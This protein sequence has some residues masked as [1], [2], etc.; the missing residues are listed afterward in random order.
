M[1]ARCAHVNY[2]SCHRYIQIYTSTPFS[3]VFPGDT[4]RCPDTIDPGPSPNLRA[5]RVPGVPRRFRKWFRWRTAVKELERC[6][7][8]IG[9]Q[10][11]DSEIIIDARFQLTSFDTVPC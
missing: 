10:G 8:E 3:R 4:L 11:P 5:D 1:F 7:R 9:R 6:W 2:R